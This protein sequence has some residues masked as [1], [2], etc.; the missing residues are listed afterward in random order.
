MIIFLIA[1]LL[2][3]SSCSLSKNSKSTPQKNGASIKSIDKE[4]DRGGVL[5]IFSTFPDTLN[6]ILSENSYMKD[7]AKLM[8]D[9]MY[10]LSSRQEALPSLV[11]S[12]QM[13]P[14]GFIWNF[15]LRENIYWHDGI[16]FS[17][18]DIEFTFNTILN[19]QINSIYKEN[20]RDIVSFSSIDNTNFR[21][22]LKRID[23]FLPWRLTFP[24]LPK[25]YYINE[26]NFEKDKQKSPPGTGPFKFYEFKENEIL[27]L[28]ANEKWWGISKDKKVRTPYIEEIE[29]K[30]G[31]NINSTSD[32]F[33]SSDID[34][35]FLKRGFWGN[36]IGRR[37]ITLQKYPSN[38]FEFLA[39][40]L[41]NKSWLEDKNLRRAV[42]L[43]LDRI[44]LINS[45]IP[46]EATP[47][48]LPIFPES[49]FNEGTI[50]RFSANKDKAKE[51][52]IANGWKYDQNGKLYKDV[53]GF[54]SYLRLSLTV[55]KE[56]Q[57]RMS[58]ANTIKKQLED[59]GM[60]IDIKECSEEE[61]FE[62]LSKK[63]FEIVISG[64]SISGYPDLA[65]LYS[66]ENPQVN[67]TG[68][69]NFDLNNLI[70]DFVTEIDLNKKR[71][72]LKSIRSIINEDVPYSGLYFYNDAVVYNK[73]YKG[74]FEPHY[75]N[76]LNDITSWFI[77]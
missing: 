50:E 34:V 44:E 41:G 76:R 31:Q 30:L 75:W 68:Y 17:S 64:I 4:P 5:R 7:Y 22:V 66:N 37:Y 10:T 29:I 20:L 14:D 62:V 70:A 45:V 48:D 42:N 58:I 61:Y 12:S 65:S 53:N 40:N 67:F 72:K 23:G 73:K 63:D 77:N 35:L 71:D 60:T 3:S 46:G 74:N 13:T 55:N 52:F 51:I 16:P 26:Q 21:I 56:N 54:S 24:I 18:Q 28:S 36:Y 69:N 49:I 33:S 19:L 6:P 32:M 27:K 38:Q 47:A 15:K 9:S 57:V 39:Y 8:Y 25:H 59:C 11:E 43:C 1:A 2:N